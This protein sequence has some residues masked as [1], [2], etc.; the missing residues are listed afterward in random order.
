[1]GLKVSGATGQAKL[2][3]RRLRLPRFSQ[4]LC[5]WSRLW[6]FPRVASAAGYGT[7][8]AL[9]GMRWRPVA[10]T[11]SRCFDS[12]LMRGVRLCA[13]ACACVFAGPACPEDY[14]H[15]QKGQSSL[16]DYVRHAFRPA[17]PFNFLPVEQ[18]CRFPSPLAAAFLCT[19]VPPSLFSLFLFLRFQATPFCLEQQLALSVN[20]T[21]NNPRLFHSR[22]R[23]RGAGSMVGQQAQWAARL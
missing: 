12:W 7:L 19:A 22:K 2:K 17:R 21:S 14:R 10:C 11:C 18:A 20:V 16:A 5:C 13:C 3:V 4:W 23:G 15:Q 1:M 9:H 6:L 8:C